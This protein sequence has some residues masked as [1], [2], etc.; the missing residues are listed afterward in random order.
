M[1]V[2]RKVYKQPLYWVVDYDTK[3]KMTE[4]PLSFKE[5][6]EL[7]KTLENP[8]MPKPEVKPEPLWS[9]IKDTVH[10]IQVAATALFL[11][12]CIAVVWQ[13]IYPTE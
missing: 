11:G 9:I 3:K 2:I 6:E 7:Q 5:A 13:S 1:Y 8:P 4:E 12:G 10:P